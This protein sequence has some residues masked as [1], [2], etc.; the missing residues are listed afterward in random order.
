MGLGT[1]CQREAAWLVTAGD[2]LPA[3][4]AAD[5]GDWDIIQ[6]FWPGSRLESSKRGIY[7]TLR[8]NTDQLLSGQRVRPQMT[9]ALKLVWT[10]KTSTAPIAENEQAAF[11]DALE[12]LVERVRGPVLDKTHGARFL[13]VGQVPV[14]RGW[15]QITWT[16]PEQTLPQRVL[17]AEF[18]YMADDFEVI[19]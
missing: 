4:L 18:T 9:F 6:A 16:D 10:I 3:L 7:V 15:P 19:G 11:A 13:S 17:R 8:R 2:G 14:G 12:A 1:A 5:G